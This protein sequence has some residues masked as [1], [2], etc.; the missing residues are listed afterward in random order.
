MSELIVEDG[1]QPRRHKQRLRALLESTQGQLRVA[2]A[3]VT[4]RD[5]LFGIEGRKVR[6]LTSLMP[7]DVASGATQIE[8]LRSLIESGVECKYLRGRPRFHAKVYIFGSDSAVVTSANLTGSAFE[9]NIEVG[10]QVGGDSVQQLA[11]WF[12]AF[13]AKADRLDVPE[14]AIWQ[15][16]TAALR[17]EFLKFKKR[18]NAKA[19]PPSGPA[20]AAPSGSI[21]ELFEKPK[22]FFVCNTNRRQGARTATHGYAVE[23]LMY[24]RHY[25]AAWEAF[26]FRDHMDE[27]QPGAAI[28]MFAKGV[29]I[30]GIG[31]AMGK[32][33]KLDSDNSGRIGD[34][35]F[36]GD[37][38][39]R[40]PVE[41]LGEWREHDAYDWKAAR[42]CTFLNVG[43][44]KYM[45]LREGVRKHFLG[46][47]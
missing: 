31:R 5:L 19:P 40:I 8:A 36:K 27:V 3:Y 23:Q 39:W 9:S 16:R 11:A 44:E 26:K 38:E 15:E 12:D 46:D 6:L 29:G 4:D 30:I 1:G 25:A 24:T 13:W 41:W 32:C 18:A 35:Y 42:N 10:V 34:P 7:M 45:G 47:A 14:L 43:D 28:F 2:S 17:R 37:R 22:G 21:R 20:K 33:Q